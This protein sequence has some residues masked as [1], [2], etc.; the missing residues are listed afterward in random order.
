M[1]DEEIRNENRS[2]PL[3]HLGFVIVICTA[4]YLTCLFI[5][6]CNS[7]YLHETFASVRGYGL[8]AYEPRQGRNAATVV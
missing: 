2:A 4:P 6:H 7:G 5:Q 8:R 1:R 3:W